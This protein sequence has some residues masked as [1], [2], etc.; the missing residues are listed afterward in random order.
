MEFG[1]TEGL[2]KKVLNSERGKKAVQGN[3]PKMKK[4]L[5]WQERN[6]PWVPWW[7]SGLGCYSMA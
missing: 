6:G 7:L 2:H 5:D 4:E 1:S 3:S